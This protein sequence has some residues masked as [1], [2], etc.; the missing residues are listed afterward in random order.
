LT[1][2][3]TD[4]VSLGNRA[5]AEGFSVHQEGESLFVDLSRECGVT[6]ILDPA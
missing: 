6:L 4:W 2:R 5:R 3:V 1:L